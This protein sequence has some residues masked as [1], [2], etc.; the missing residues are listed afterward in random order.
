V[1]VRERDLCLCSRRNGKTGLVS[2]TSR[3]D[4]RVACTQGRKKYIIGTRDS[5][6]VRLALQVIFY[7]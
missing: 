6:A 2:S 7:I 5:A 1:C 4:T 3:D